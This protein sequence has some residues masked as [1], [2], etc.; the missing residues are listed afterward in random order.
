[1][2]SDQLLPIGSVVRL[3]D[4][5]KDL[6]IIGILPTN[7]GTTYDYLGVFYPEGY[8]NQ[9]YVFL[10]NHTDIEKIKFVGFMDVSYQAFRSG[11]AK[12][13]DGGQS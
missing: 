1:M 9:E 7:E 5:E 2:T 8:L 13:L 6:M 12:I 3:K 10:F 4:G 11:L